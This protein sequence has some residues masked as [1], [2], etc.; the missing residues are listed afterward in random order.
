MNIYEIENIN[1]I[2]NFYIKVYDLIVT[3]EYIDFT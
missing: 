1:M 3:Y 2:S